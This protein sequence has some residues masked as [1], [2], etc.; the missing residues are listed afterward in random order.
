ME[1]KKRNYTALRVET[2]NFVIF[3][4]LALV[5]NRRIVKV[6]TSIDLI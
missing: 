5:V 2:V 4:A 6:R 3:L 1:L